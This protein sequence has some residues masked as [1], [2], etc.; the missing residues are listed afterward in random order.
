MN[1]QIHSESVR[2]LGPRVE[3][4]A[5]I[6]VGS[7][8][9]KLLVADVGWRLRPVLK[10]RLRTGLGQGA[11]R[12]HCLQPEAIARTVDVVQTFA[13]EAVG[14]GC[15]SIRVLATSAAREATNSHELAQAVQRATGLSVEVIS[16]EQ[17][18]DYV[19]EGV[20]SD[21]LIGAQPVLI[22]KVGGG[23]T[24]WVV[25][26][27]G[28]VHFRKSTRIGTVRLLEFNPL[29]DPPGHA[30]LARLRATVREFVRAE[31]SPSLEP[32]LR[33][34]CGR[35]VRLVGLG[36]SLQALARVGGGPAGSC[37]RNTLRRE[38]LVKQVE[39][40]WGLT[41]LERR[42][43]SGL[44]AE[45][46][47]VILPGGVICEAVLEQFGFEE[48]LISSRGPREGALL[49]GLGNPDQWRWSGL[50][51]GSEAWG[52]GIQPVF[53]AGLLKPANPAP[54]PS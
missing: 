5:V 47:E 39:L 12:T 19:F 16:G 35:A 15:T 48:V 24:E 22:I 25:A 31:V 7:N 52:M 18:A 42:R 17:E 44:D 49:L 32:V 37:Q 51:L 36:G 27:R 1:P 45:R 26:E 6:D 30:A 46:A 28:V 40:V 43:L 21:P 54:L 23:S 14:L 9:V 53:E 50:R 3:R 20:S 4:R 33:A 29:G 8:S 34:F 38:Q 11:F 13:A 10:L 2:D 41:V